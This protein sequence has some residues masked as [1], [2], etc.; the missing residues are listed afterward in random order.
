M[1]NFRL[2]ILM[3]L[4]LVTGPMMVGIGLADENGGKRYQVTITNVT[5]GQVITPPVLI[6][7]NED[8]QL[9]TVGSP[10]I[11]ELAVLAEDGVTVNLL[12]LLDT[13]PTVYDSTA[14]SGPILPGTS[15]TLDIVTKAG[16]D[17]I[18]AVGMLATTNDA[19]FAI[20]G[21]K[22]PS[23]GEKTLEAKAYDAG[24]EANTESCAFIPGPP[25]G[26]GGVHDPA[27]AEGYVHVHAGIH[28]IADL[29]PADHDWRNPVAEITI[30]RTQ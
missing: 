27:A 5:R 16:F 17:R 18:S 8:F 19:F 29:V 28:G 22:A 12:A 1:K 3:A 20:E 6:S 15:L 11:P 7:H 30:Q 9:F 25:C 23:G 21:V 14:A 10:A 2:L 4:T 24:S 13:L 26:S